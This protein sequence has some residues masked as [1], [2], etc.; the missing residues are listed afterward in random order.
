M[1][2]RKLIY[3]TNVKIPGGDAQSIQVEAMAKVFSKILGKNF[4]LISPKHQLNKNL[5]KAFL[6]IKLPVPQFLPR[7]VRYF[8]TIIFSF[9]A[10]I[11][12]RWFKRNYFIYSR[13]IGIVFFYKILG[14]KT[15][16]EIHKPFTTKLGHFLFKILKNK[17][18]I[19]AISE[20]LKKFLLSKHNFS[21][22]FILV[23]HSG[24]FYENFLKIEENKEIL[25][26]RYLNL[27][28]NDFVVLYSGSFQKGKSIDLI[29]EVARNLKDIYFVILGGKKEEISQLKNKASNNV[30][31]LG[32]K[33]YYQVPYYLK[34]ADI[35]ILPFFKNLETINWCSPLKTFEYLASGVP[36]LA[37]SLGSLKE[38]LNEKNSFLFNP[39]NLKEIIE[40]IKFIREN[41][42]LA[43][44]KAS[45]GERES[46]KFDWQK[47][48]EKIL[49][50]LY[51]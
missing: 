14:F 16:Y 6:W 33:P 30:L 3:I 20:S 45:F 13:D 17:I 50:F 9:F 23:A 46:L 51:N 37:S 26:K 35:L 8:L 25:K 31:F 10:L 1:F 29:L 11:K 42:Q 21:Q 48:A 5:K 43:K 41:Y 40:K 36:I 22:D 4:V 28:K 27:N 39:E 2:E 34:S 15:A 24:V 38:I 47:R 44:I 32:R 12:Y 49:K 18:K 7:M 19:I